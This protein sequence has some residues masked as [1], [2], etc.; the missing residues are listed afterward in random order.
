MARSSPT[1]LLRPPFAPSV[2]SAIKMWSC[3]ERA[4][5]VLVPA[6]LAPPEGKI[7]Y[8]S[9][10]LPIAAVLVAKSRVEALKKAL[11]TV[12]AIAPFEGI[13]SAGADE[14][15]ALRRLV[16]GGP[17]IHPPVWS[18]ATPLPL[19]VKAQIT[20]RGLAPAF[21]SLL[22]LVTPSKELPDD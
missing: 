1:K 9:A 4:D 3:G 11:A 19:D 15:G 14:I 16:Q 21:P 10:P 18:D 7:L 6:P 5:A 12:G 2:E 22:G 20:F 17:A 13:S 8:Q